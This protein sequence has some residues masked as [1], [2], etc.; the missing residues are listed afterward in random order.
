MP[1]GTT[2]K[3]A[4]I[5]MACRF[6]GDVRSPDDLWRVVSTATDTISELPA[7]R[8]W[9]IE[10][11]YDPD[12]DA[13]GKLYTRQ[14]GFIYDAHYFDA[15]FFGISPREATATDPQQRLLL[16]T[17]WEA[18][19]RAQMDP[20]SLRGS[21]AGVFIGLS[22]NDY[23][24]R[25][26]RAEESLEGYL[27]IGGAAS[28]ASGRIAYTLGLEGPAITVDTACSSSLVAL[29]LACQAL[30][31]GEC[32]L[33]LA[34][35]AAIMAT[36]AHL[37]SF[38]R[39]RALSP[40]GRCRAFAASADGTGFAEG[41]GMLAVQRLEDALRDGRPVLAVIAGSATNQDGASAGLTA[42][43][44][45]AQQRVIRA[46]LAEAGVRPAQVD[47]VEAHGTGTKLG[48]P[49][50]AEAII[51]VYG[52]DRPVDRPLRIGSVK[53][54]IG[55]TQHA[56]GIAG[57]I[58]VVMAMRHG[59]LPKTLHVDRPT[60]RV[61]WSAGRAALLTEPL[62]WPA[63]DNQRR[64]GVSSFGISGT[65]A[66]VILEQFG[67][68]RGTQAPRS[69]RPAGTAATGTAAALPVVP[70]P[71]SAMTA[72]ALQEQASRLIDQMAAV[73]DTGIADIGHSLVTTRGLFPH[74]AVVI[75]SGHDDLR[76]RLR[77]LAAGEQAP[78]LVTGRA[79]AAGKV[80]FVFP[81][82]GCQ[83]AGMAARLLRESQVFA[84]HLATCAD[85]LAPY[86][87]ISLTKLLSGAEDRPELH[88][89]EIIQPAL[90]AVTTSLAA[91][92]RSMGVEPDAVVG[93]SQGEIPA[94]YVAGALSLADAVRIA[95][96]RS[97]LAAPA[98][99]GAMAAVRLGVD[100]IRGRLAG[101]GAALDI[102]AI[103]SPAST[104]VSG[105][106]ADVLA[107][108]AELAAEGIQ[109][110]RLPVTY[111]SHSR[112][113]TAI[114][115]RLEQALHGI[116]PRP[117]QIPFYST[118]TGAEMDTSQLGP[119]YWY[120]N[121]R[122]PVLFE[123]AVRA[124][125]DQGYRAFIES[126][127]HPVLVPGIGETLEAASR[128][129][130]T[131]NA[132]VGSL[133][134]EAGGWDQFLTEVARAH[135]AG[136]PVT[137]DS[138]FAGRARRLID[139]PTYPFQRR[140]YWLGS[141]APAGD[142]TELGLEPVGHGILSALVELGDGE[143]AVLTGRISRHE[144]PW[145]ADHKVAQAVLV[146]GAVLAEL[147]VTAA[148][149]T[150]CHRVEE[151]TVQLPLVLPER[152]NVRIRVTVDAA[153]GNG[154]RSLKIHS[155]LETTLPGAA[156]KDGT[157]TLHATGKLG[158]E[159]P[160]AAAA[161]T[162]GAGT[163]GAGTAGA[164]AIALSEQWP[165]AGSVPV[166]VSDLY[167]TLA[168]HGH[169]YGPAF[170]CLQAAW[171]RGDDLYAEAALPGEHRPGRF[172]VHP[173]L[174][175]A[176][177][178]AAG[179]ASR[180][181]G[182][183]SE[184]LLACSWSG[185]SVHGHS[186][187]GS[188]A[189]GVRMRLRAIDGGIS[190]LELL[191]AL[192]SPVLSVDSVVL[193]PVPAAEL[194]L[195]R[196]AGADDLFG[197]D[198]KPLPSVRSGA[199]AASRS[200][201]EGWALIGPD[202]RTLG[203]ALRGDGISAE[204]YPGLGAL[205]AA[206][207]AGAPPPRVVLLACMPSS[208]GSIA[209]AARAA[210]QRVLADLQRWLSA[211]RFADSRLVVVT[212]G[213]GE[214]CSVRAATAWGLVRSAQMEHPG[215]I[216]LLDLDDR[217]ASLRALPA[218]LAAGEPQ[219]VIRDGV[220]KVPRLV[221]ADPGLRPPADP[222]WRL[223]M[224]AR[225]TLDGL[226]LTPYPAAARLPGPGQVRVAV[227]AAGLNFRDVLVA[228]DRYPAASLGLEIAGVVTEAGPGVS[229]LSPGDRVMG[230][231]P[232]S[233][234]PVAVADHRCLVKMPAGWSFAQAAAAPVAFATAYVA[235]SRL[236]GIQPGDRVLIHAAAGGV[237]MA[238]LQ[239][240]RHWGGEAY[241]TASPGKWAVLERQG[242][243]RD[244]IASSR[245]LDF[246]QRLSPGPEGPGLDIVLNCLAG[247]FAD[248]SMRLLVKG[249]R[250][251]ELGRADT[252]TGRAVNADHPDIAYHALDLT[253][254]SPDRM[255]E[256]LTDLRDLF[257]SGQLSP[258]P[259]TAWDVRNA[260]EAFRCMREAQH[261]GK[262]V[263]T[264][265]ARPDP[266]GTILITGG[267]T[268]LGALLARHLV[269]RHGS[270]HLLLA[271]R[272]GA[273]AP[274][275]AGLTDEF[276]RLGAEVR[277][278]ACDVADRDAVARLLTS[279]PA[280]HPVTCVIHA[281]GVLDDCALTSMTPQ[282]LDAVL[283]PKVEGAWNLH[284]L[285]QELDLT[286][287]IVFSST[288]GTFGNGGQANYAAANAFLDALVTF[289]RRRGLPAASLAWGPWAVP[290]GMTGHLS[291]KDRAR[292]SQREAMLLLS[293]DDGLDLFDRACG[294]PQPVVVPARL[295][296]AVLRA[297]ARHGE[298]HPMLT[299]LVPDARHPAPAVPGTA[300]AGKPDENRLTRHLAGLS[301]RERDQAMLDLI[302]ASAAIVLARSAPEAIETDRTFHELG[303]DSLS[304]IEL[305]N[306]LNTATGLR[307]P[308]TLVY[309][310][311]TPA[312]LAAALQAQFATDRAAATAR[313]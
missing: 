226:V 202:A 221:H 89:D 300:T 5:G 209:G 245:T 107:F 38:S 30:R 155:R 130:E 286:G 145:L 187:H 96:R 148:E 94:A 205:E 214:E 195:A 192:N 219:A 86:L 14:G 223:G 128:T 191:D 208:S 141:A 313:S 247:E 92:W 29:H 253:E 207:D 273:D 163:A 198:W 135:V 301:A 266:E 90:F 190:Q 27:G 76:D 21:A 59:M 1:R 264:M 303:F 170:R 23:A 249:G 31:H 44:G 251:I 305:C 74:R 162:A 164:G 51:S 231:V 275:A 185:I 151:L 285:T 204:S 248:A 18:V 63:H 84:E 168:D 56:A 87:G 105:D 290:T 220:I 232:N 85:E 10:N 161:G 50:E 189:V 173:V 225:G 259:V 234:G 4:I 216:V 139:L 118:V 40:D 181:P 117:S 212:G 131:A 309:E 20:A 57:V 218:A 269:A 233:I 299:A 33:A 13:P 111:A 140:P 70:V 260:P 134:R 60:P 82:Q 69:A 243:P 75:A 93:H 62:P 228:L 32:D 115:G 255:R 125:A 83:W 157:W 211:G 66:H 138:A 64:A 306:R 37:L 188:G 252:R 143:A 194:V 68:A 73:P 237:G 283:R 239:L 227:R 294:F 271:S 196:S 132:V 258:L 142:A 124:L 238:A 296:T 158:P 104:V 292:L 26:H 49:I 230:M 308:T 268:G 312:D 267:T 171:R 282:R 53:S 236:G 261:T 28:V 281:A 279:V 257:Q 52:K 250:F 91:L 36:P 302:R 235:L 114:A 39:Q 242:V 54:N 146:P 116:T 174:L 137:W 215:H 7:D 88:Q 167:D 112:R 45:T 165:P 295:D 289:R 129:E 179:L 24:T 99:G 186:V 169:S 311:R 65:N 35:G 241:A 43:S 199:S 287:F 72:S 109:T 153:D 217:R 147:A 133:R 278:A 246:A 272:R 11:L 160:G 193:R 121:L 265:P 222:E 229:S 183:G 206:L 256:I 297:Q 136:V 77:A 110:R 244:R 106:T 79:H 113:V 8:G 224:T 34:G 12:P 58:K 78:G 200:D 108:T 240:T 310:Y 277:I 71:L 98:I 156:A 270:R 288:I 178:P 201:T 126:G 184:A 210:A 95:V 177:I 61:D 123:K 176:V 15:D 291:E 67:T 159:A 9:D 263:L 19:E 3:I 97:Q 172:A 276:A 2:D 122:Q 127:P 119:A 213:A 48:D 102:A 182:S 197:V 262:I 144:H 254:L 150:G 154:I 280:R 152:G 203:R 22:P 17:A 307:L 16:E 293:T 101:R 298:A 42:P 166:D 274:G 149:K 304:A 103:N 80:V 81:G 41:V 100:D 25:A 175:D 46:A 180:P 6:S 284:E 120:A 55:H 47:T